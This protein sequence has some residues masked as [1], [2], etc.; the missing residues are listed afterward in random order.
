M[1]TIQLPNGKRVSLATYAAA[2]RALKVM[3]KDAQVNG[4]A[5]H[6]ESVESI[7]HAIRGG[8]SERINRHDARHG[9][10]RKWDNDY[11]VQAW[12]DSRK[13]RDIANRVRVYQFETQEA[14][15][16]FGHLLAS[17]ND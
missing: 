2:W 13:L 15:M 4:F 5:W 12:R 7:L 1:K 10:G 6:H 3:P 9:K 8:L 17:Y 14:K 16:R 11:F